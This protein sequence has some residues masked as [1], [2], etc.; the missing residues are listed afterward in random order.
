MTKPVVYI[1]RSTDKV[2][3]NFEACIHLNLIPRNFHFLSCSSIDIDEPCSC[4]VRTEP[5]ELPTELPYA[6]HKTDELEQWIKDRYASSIFNICEHQ[7]LPLMTGEPLR[8]FMDE[9]VK[10]HAVQTPANIPIHFREE[11]KHN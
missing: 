5:P 4:P 1:T 8:L 10:P 7:A 2:F 11:V 9:I 6:E 3:L